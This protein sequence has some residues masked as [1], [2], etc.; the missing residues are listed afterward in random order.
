MRGSA[1]LELFGCQLMPRQQLVEVGAVTPCQ[2][3]GLTHIPSRDLQDL[4]EVAA[5][6]L[7]ARLIEGGQPSR[8]ATEGLLHQLDRNDR[9]LR[10]RNVLADYVVQLA[11]VAR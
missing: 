6:E 5:R 2:P 7:I 10:Q 4:R 11:D 9:C 1:L 8:G 3:C